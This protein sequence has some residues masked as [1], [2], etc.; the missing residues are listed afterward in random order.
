MRT[1][2]KEGVK[3]LVVD[4]EDYMRE[5]VREALEGAGFEIEE[6][7]DGNTAVSMIRQYPYDVI[8]T[9]LRIPGV[10][11][12]KVMQEALTIFP[13]TIVIIMTGYGNIQTAVDAIR[14]GAYDY[15]P[16]PFQLDE[17]VMRVEK[18]IHDRQLKSENS[19]LR[20]ELQGKY[21]F[22]NLVGHSA[23]IQQIYR[24][25][26]AVAHKTSTILITGETGTGKELIA[27]AIH[28][29]GSRKEHPMVSVNCG[30]IAANLLETEL[31]GHVKGAFTGAHQHR[32]GRFEQANHGTLFLDEVAN[33]PL[34]LQV[35]LLR[36]LQE[37]ELQ[38]VGSNTTIKVDVRIIA[39]TNGDLFEKVKKGEFREDLY[40][41]LNVIPIA[42]PALR[43]RR[44]DIPLLV[45]HFTRKFCSEQQVPLRQVS[46]EA[47]KQIIA[48]DWPGNVRQL[49]NAVE[50]AVTLSG[51]RQLLD[52]SDFPTVGRALAD[53]AMF[54]S[55]AIPQDG[56]YFNTVVSELERR[57]ILQSLEATG[58]N[59]KRAASLLHLKRTTFVEKLKRMGMETDSLDLESEAA[60]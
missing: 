20:S 6:A 37:R 60:V 23:P 3:I 36:V 15:L 45:S 50:M 31:F 7:A 29:N 42:I 28:F 30:A 33:M 25:V 34:D 39:A 55:I 11:G 38:R 16:K 32:V 17:L 51:D 57:L 59:K 12:E 13:E 52:V 53:D 56:I 27:K 2:G 47:I 8:I 21:Q 24:M 46:H 58:G 48:F 14:M 44:E 10:P 49:E 43:Q 26:A 22:T 4:D 54:G 19:M 18:G 35:K 1:M 40:Y 5:I 9:D 41:R